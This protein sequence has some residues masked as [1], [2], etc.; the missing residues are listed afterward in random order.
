MGF[1]VYDNVLD[2]V[3]HEVKV[4]YKYP[5]TGIGNSTVAKQFAK[6]LAL[7]DKGDVKEVIW[8]FYKSP[9]IGKVGASPAL[10]PML[11]EAQ[12]NGYKISHQILELEPSVLAKMDLN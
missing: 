1:G 8:T 10:Q 4:G 12:N 9:K 7:L 6:D 3:A 2:E 11:K 5:S